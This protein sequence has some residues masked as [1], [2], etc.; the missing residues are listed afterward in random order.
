MIP[1]GFEL[2]LSGGEQVVLLLVLGL[3]AVAAAVPASGPL[4]V[5]GVL[6]ARRDGGRVLGNGLWYWVWGTAVSWAVM[7]GCA[8]LG[9]GWWAVPV[10]WL[11]GWLAA[12]VLRPPGSLAR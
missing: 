10:A 1:L 9:L 8:R 6:R 11:P 3:L 5:V 4:G 12:W 2:E 7:L